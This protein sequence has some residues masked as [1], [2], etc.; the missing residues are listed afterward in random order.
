MS[1]PNQDENANQENQVNEAEL[2]ARKEHILKQILTPD[3][4]NRLN[5]IKMVKQDLTT[6]VENH[7]IGLVTQGKINSQITDDQLKQILLSLQQP[8]RDFKITRR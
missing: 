7:L 2:A 6:L 3:A 4:R 8:K 5:N 1:Y